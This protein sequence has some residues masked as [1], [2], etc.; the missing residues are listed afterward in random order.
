[1]AAHRVGVKDAANVKRRARGLAASSTRVAVCYT[2]PN[3]LPVP[4]S[5]TICGA[6]DALSLTINAPV[7]KV[8]S[9]GLKVTSTLQLLPG[10]KVLAHCF[11]TAN[12]APVVVSLVTTTSI[13]ECFESVFLIVTSFLLVLPILVLSPK[14]TGFGLNDSIPKGVGVDVGVGLAVA[15][16]VAVAVLVAV[17]VA[18]GVPL[19]EV[20]VAVAV[21]VLVAVAVAVAVPLVEVAVAVAVAVLVAVAVAVGVPPVEVAVAVAVLVAVAVGV[22]VAPVAVAVGVGLVNGVGPLGGLNWKELGKSTF[23]GAISGGLSYEVM[24]GIQLNGS[25]GADVAALALGS[26]T[27]AAAV[28]AGLWLLRSELPADLRRKKPTTLPGVAEGAAAETMS[29]GTEP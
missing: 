5:G 21:A 28:A 16:A 14:L 11:A 19:V 23:I 9:L 1:M 4:E 24:R 12:G 13:P 29:S 26:L 22:A 7:C 8:S 6:P 27:W 10:F 15:V 25:R 18:V 2:P 17:A 3:Y 20:A